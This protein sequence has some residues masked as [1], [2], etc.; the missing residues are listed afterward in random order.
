MEAAARGELWYSGDAKT[1]IDAI[2][3]DPEIYELRRTA[4]KKMLRFYHAEPVERPADL[5]AL[6]RHIK[7]DKPTQQVEIEHAADR[8]RSG[9]ATGWT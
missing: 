5:I 1:P 3:H 6:H 4:L 8:Y 9:R 7:E 2:H